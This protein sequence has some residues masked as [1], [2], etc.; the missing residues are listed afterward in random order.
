[1]LC[2][3]ARSVR[4]RT[5]PSHAADVAERRSNHELRAAAPAS[6]GERRTLSWLTL[7]RAPE[8]LPYV[9]GYV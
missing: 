1:V 2:P 4:R 5:V 3:V 9:M 6:F 8:F 7:G